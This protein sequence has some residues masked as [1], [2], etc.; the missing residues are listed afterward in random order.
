MKQDKQKRR[1]WFSTAEY[2]C[3]HLALRSQNEWH[4]WVFLYSFFCWDLHM[5]VSSF[6]INFYRFCVYNWCMLWSRQVWWNGYVPVSRNG[7]QEC[8]KP[9]LV[10]WVPPNRSR[11]PD[12]GW[13]CV[14]RQ[15]YWHVPSYEFA[16]HDCAQNLAL[17][18]GSVFRQY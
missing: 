4:D 9:C 2:W 12:S 16:G 15:A 1:Q 11:E 17:V 13:R 18:Y 8:N 5:L 14:V 6:V 3:I 10:G 7:M